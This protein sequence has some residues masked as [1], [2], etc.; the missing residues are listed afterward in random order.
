MT[1]SIDFTQKTF[2]DR[3]LHVCQLADVDPCSASVSRD[4][5]VNKAAVSMWKKQETTPKGETV[6]RIADRFSVSA[7]FLLGRTNDKT[8]YTT[9]R[10]AAV[11]DRLTRKLGM[12]D[13]LG[14]ARIEAYIDGLT[15]GR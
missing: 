15:A 11:P 8:D 12:L 1:D 5:G 4:I 2:Y 14:L 3:F 13:P 10:R 6:K 7:A 9:G